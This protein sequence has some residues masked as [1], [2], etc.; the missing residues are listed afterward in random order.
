MKAICS[1]FQRLAVLVPLVVC[2]AGGVSQQAL[3]GQSDIGTSASPLSIP[4][5]LPATPYPDSGVPEG[6]FFNLR[7]Y[8][9]PVGDYLADKGIYLTGRT[10]QQGIGLTSGGN[11]TG[12][13]FE[14]FNLFGVDLD[15]GKIAGIKGGSF[16]FQM[17][18]LSGIPFTGRT[19][20]FYVYNRAFA[21]QAGVRMNEFS[22]EQ[23]FGGLVDIRAGRIPVGTEFDTERVYCEFI[24]A[25]CAL[26][27][28]YAFTKGY[29]AYDT[30]SWA[31]IAQVKLPQHFY[32]HTGI[33]ADQPNLATIGHWGWP[34]EDWSTDK[35]R[36][37]TIPVQIGYRTT[38]K[39][40]PYPKSYA[41]GG[42]Y[43]TGDYVDPIDNAAGQNRLTAG[44][45]PR[46]DHGKSGIWVQ[47]EQT[48]WRPDMATNRAL[49]LFAGANVQTSGEANITNAYFAGLSYNGPFA[50]R[51]YD[52]VNFMGEAINMGGA[53][54]NFVD[55]TLNLERMPGNYN[56]HEAFVEVNYGIALAPGMFLKP[57][58]EYVWNPDQVN[59]RPV[60]TLHHDTI[61]GVAFSAFLPE[62]LGMPRLGGGG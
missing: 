33:F 41:V 25:M 6:Y 50:G 35:I 9:K 52:T 19:G 23:N 54:T 27:A 42:Y 43:D 28:G 7:P 39:N 38:F 62:T 37:A 61:I 18:E 24:Y 40:D 48:V 5:V 49:T 46:L 3:A 56:P 47:A 2:A 16:H 60:S 58:F 29:P 30:A 17:N 51:P 55:T 21:L 13:I 59:S 11:R 36:G 31:G 12:T 32:F 4:P 10:L 44:G 57:N 20:S 34:G 1:H 53:Y 45:A 26:P 22:Y 14:G 8:G 15:M